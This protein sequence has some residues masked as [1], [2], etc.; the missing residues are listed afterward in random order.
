MI[1]R[2]SGRVHDSQNQ[3]S[4]A[5]EPVYSL[6]RISEFP[7]MFWGMLFFEISNSW[8]SK[9]SLFGEQTRARKSWRSVLEFL[10]HLEYEIDIYQKHELEFFG[11]FQL[12]KLRQFKVVSIE[13]PPHISESHPCTSPPLGGHDWTANEIETHRPPCKWSNESNNQLLVW[14]FPKVCMYDW[15]TIQ[16]IDE[17]LGSPLIR[18]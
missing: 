9:I 18:S 6:K 4:W 16:C 13:G 14:Q 1:F 7:N 3:L 12:K 17:L 15:L 5:L 2:S 11:N 8:T 10:E